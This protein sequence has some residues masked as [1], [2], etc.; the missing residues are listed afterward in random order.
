MFDWITDLIVNIL[1]FIGACLLPFTV[2]SIFY[3]IYYKY[4]KKIEIPKK[5]FISKVKRVSFIKRLFIDFP[6]QFVLD[7]LTRNP[8]EFGLYGFH[9]FVGEQGSGKTVAT[10]EFLRRIKQKYPLCQIATNFEYKNEDSQINSWKDLVFNNNGIYG[11]V[12]V[13][14]EVQNWFSCNQSKDFPPEM[15]HEITQERKQRKIFIGTTQRFER[16][17]KPLREQINYLYYPVTIAGCLTI[18]KV[19]KPS[20]DSEGQITKLKGARFYFFVHDKE[21]RDS[22]DTYHK[23]KKQAE[24][25]FYDNKSDDKLTITT[26]LEQKTTKSTRKR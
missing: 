20:V 2:M 1:L 23:I 6:K 9:L 19:C 25:G 8:N 18:V 3:Y 16:M 22:F 7:M 15:I 17:A 5:E 24:A 4:V 12:D 14:D 10:A 13:V 26:V 11:Q 21:I